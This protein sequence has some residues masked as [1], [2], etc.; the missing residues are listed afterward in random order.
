MTGPDE[1]A[2]LI[3][4]L[5][6]G[7]REHQAAAAADRP[8]TYQ[9]AMSL[10]LPDQIDRYRELA[11]RDMTARSI[12]T[13]QAH[14]EYDEEKARILPIGKYQPLTAAEHLELL[15]LGEAIAFHYRHPAGVDRA[16]RAGATWEQIAAA[17]NTT[18]EAAQAAYREWTEGQHQY[19][20]MSDDDYAAAIARA[21][22]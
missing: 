4:Q 8:Q 18:A 15:A 12:A 21:T 6:Q 2:N 20:G 19:V 16:V 9:D 10:G 7:Y 22:G 1:T 13:L 3:G 17:R 5:T 14:G 11:D